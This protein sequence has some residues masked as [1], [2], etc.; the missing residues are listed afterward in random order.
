MTNKTML[1]TVEE[2]LE[3]VAYNDKLCP[4]SLKSKALS[5]AL[6][7][8][9]WT[10]KQAKLAMHILKSSLSFVGEHLGMEFA[11]ELNNLLQD[12]VYRNKFRKIDY[13][14]ILT[15][16]ERGGVTVIYFKFPYNERIVKQLRCLKKKYGDFLM[17]LF[18][19]EEKAWMFDYSDVNLYWLTLL[20]IRHDFEIK[21][22]RILDLFEK[23]RNKKRNYKKSIIEIKEDNIIFKNTSDTLRDNFNSTTAD[24]KFLC[25]I[26]FLKR[27]QLPIQH[28]HNLKTLS[29]KIA[30]SEKNDFFV[31]KKD[32][33]KVEFLNAM[34]ELNLFPAVCTGYGLVLSSD[35]TEIYTW[36]LAFE[37]ANITKNEICLTPNFLTHRLR[38]Y[39]HDEQS[40]L[41][42]K[43]KQ[44]SSKYNAVPNKKTKIVFMGQSIATNI[45]P[46]FNK[47]QCSFNFTD[48]SYYMSG[49]DFVNSVVEN[50]PKRL[51]YSSKEPQN[52]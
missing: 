10:E 50:L 25:K 7:E 3:I 41:L 15:L 11:L 16:E 4:E 30:Y 13:N 45:R 8:S 17:A 39:D 28:S 1:K 36:L 31:S 35:L 6:Q 43:I 51:Y 42:E 14:K 32:Y 52:I 20:A 26:D 21:D 38:E 9:A 23:I 12:P 48:I 37:K 34:H 44:L 49:S 27:Y 2:A 29:E 19:D 22:Q 5:L 33:S 18:N 47:I 40:D 46:M 24:M